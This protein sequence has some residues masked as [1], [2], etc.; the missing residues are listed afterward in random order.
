MNKVK[1]GRMRRR[2]PKHLSGCFVFLVPRQAAAAGVGRFSEFS[3]KDHRIETLPD[4]HLRGSS[5]I[6]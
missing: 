1:A 6:S 2:T 3:N 5:Y 4:V